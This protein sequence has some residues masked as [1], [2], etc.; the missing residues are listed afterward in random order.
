MGFTTVD[1]CRFDVST[2]HN[3]QHVYYCEL[4]AKFENPKTASPASVPVHLDALDGRVA[5]REPVGVD[6]VVGRVRVI[7][8][9]DLDNVLKAKS[10][11]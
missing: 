1:T 11:Y 8:A 3:V 2:S 4:L 7:E 5:E 6:D 10:R 9:E